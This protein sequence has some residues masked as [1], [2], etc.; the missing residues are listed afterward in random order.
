MSGNYLPRVI[1]KGESHLD[2]GHGRACRDSED[3]T[4]LAPWQPAACSLEG[5]KEPERQVG[6]ATRDGNGNGHGHGHGR[7]NRIA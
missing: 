6:R 4:A 7:G 2:L 1:D 5:R 3:K